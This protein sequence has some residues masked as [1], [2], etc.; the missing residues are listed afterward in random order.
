MKNVS[1]FM[2]KTFKLFEQPKILLGLRPLEE[3]LCFIGAGTP[4][5]YNEAASV[6][7]ERSWE[8]E[9]T[10]TITSCRYL[11]EVLTWG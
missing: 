1:Y 5:W 3:G 7:V 2:E 11:G 6:S 8:M 4:E 10:S 9:P